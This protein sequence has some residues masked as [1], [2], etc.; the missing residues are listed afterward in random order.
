MFV[1]GNLAYHY[2]L[3]SEF[4]SVTILI[5]VVGWGANELLGTC[6]KILVVVSYCILFFIVKQ[7]SS[8]QRF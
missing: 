5:Y 8:S 7:Y 4:C 1:L 2:R 6:G 3:T